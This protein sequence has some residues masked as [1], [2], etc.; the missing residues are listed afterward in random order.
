MLALKEKISLEL[1]NIELLIKELPPAEMLPEL[2]TLEL[3]GVATLLHNFYN[4]IE[5]IIKQISKYEKIDIPSGSSWH[6]EMLGLAVE[7][8]IISK[9]LKNVLGGFLAF[10]HFFT[11]AYALDLYPER[12]TPLVKELLPT[13]L[14][15]KKDISNWK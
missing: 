8:K 7:N 11:H 13:F 3:A 1:K 12:I 4:G 14:A 9:E 15:F 10:R 6:K 2:S 5:N